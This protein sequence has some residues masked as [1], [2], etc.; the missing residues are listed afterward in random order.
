M[1]RDLYC[2][3]AP[4]YLTILIFLSADKSQIT[5]SLITKAKKTTLSSISM[6]P[7][8]FIE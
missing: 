7:L 3:S 4:I 5:I 8:T 1:F 2:I 6:F